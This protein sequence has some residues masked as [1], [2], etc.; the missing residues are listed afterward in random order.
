MNHKRT[1]I[2]MDILLTYYKPLVF[3]VKLDIE[4]IK[5]LVHIT[6]QQTYAKQCKFTGIKGNL[7]HSRNV[8]DHTISHFTTGQ[9]RNH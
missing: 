2:Y 7:V 8:R 4:D 9:R 1:F 6:K 3:S 5:K